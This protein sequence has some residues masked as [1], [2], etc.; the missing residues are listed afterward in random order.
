MDRLLKVAT[1]A[2][3]ATVTL[4]EG[5]RVRPPGLLPRLRITLEVAEV[6]LP[7]WSSTSTVTPVGL[8][9]GT[10]AIVLVGCAAKANW[11]CAAGV[12]LKV[13]EMAIPR[14]PSAAE[15]V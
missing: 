3:A 4:A 2:T 13:L 14:G 7:N 11:Y 8:S 6:R 12:M 9:M 5:L 10:P 15:R 1:P